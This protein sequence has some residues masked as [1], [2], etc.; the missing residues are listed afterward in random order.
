MASTFFGLE[1]AKRG[2]FTQQGALYVTGH[3]IS[4]ANTPGYTRQRVDFVTTTPFSSPGMNRPGYP[5]QLGTGVE[6]GAI[7]R[8][9]DSF[10]DV[11]LRTQNTNLGFYGGMTESLVKMEEIMN[12]PSSSGLHS[13]MN[14]FWNSLQTLANNTENSGARDVVTSTGQMVADTFNYYYNSLTRVQ[15]DLG[16]QIDVTAKAINDTLNSINQLNKQISEVEPHGMLPNDLYDQRDMLVDKLSG[17]INIKVTK[18]KPDHYGNA[19]EIADGLYNIELVQKDGKPYD[20]PINLLEVNRDG[21]SDFKQLHVYKDG[22]KVEGVYIDSITN[23]PPNAELPTDLPADSLTGDQMNFSGELS[24]LIQSFGYETEDGTVKGHYPEMIDNINKMAQAFAAEFNL[25]HK[26][27]YEL[28]GGKSNLDFFLGDPDTG[29]ITAA[30]IK[31]N[32]VIKN[33]P[34]KI[35]A[36]LGDGNAGNNK[37]AQALADLKT[38]AF[39]EYLSKDQIDPGLTGNIDSFYQGIIGK[40]GVVSQSAAQDYSNSSIIAASVEERRQSVSAVSLDEEMINMIK[41]QHAYNACAR[42]IT[43]VDEMLDK[44]INGMGIVGR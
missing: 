35:A 26:Q 4:N 44:I 23:F 5:G 7:T 31:V 38:K 17:L 25:V 40:L 15:N 21:T 6:A 3:N 39:S 41:F 36:G 42:N 12:E 34:S 30:N 29:E 24:A 14:K 1:T 11:Q 28:N 22:N 27:G 32:S 2:M 33:D 9:R 16:S 37:N 10:L 13:V 19:K 43:V 8:V 18:V 20:P